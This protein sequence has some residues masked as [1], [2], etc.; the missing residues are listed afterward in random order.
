MGV[1]LGWKGYEQLKRLER[2]EAR[3]KIRKARKTIKYRKVRRL[4]MLRLQWSKKAN[5]FQDGYIRLKITNFRKN[6]GKA[7]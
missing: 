1:S 2:K 7:V 5:K 3:P 4:N 6:I